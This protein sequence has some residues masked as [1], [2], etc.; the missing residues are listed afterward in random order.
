[1]DVHR[2]LPDPAGRIRPTLTP[3]GLEF[4]TSVLSVSRVL[5]ILRLLRLVKLL[6]PMRDLWMPV[7]GTLKALEVIFWAIVLLLIVSYTCGILMTFI[8]GLA[9]VDG[10]ESALIREAG[11]CGVHCFRGPCPR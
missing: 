8:Y 2:R 7:A 10:G 5:L 4:G 11:L 6:M 1:M 3:L 9:C